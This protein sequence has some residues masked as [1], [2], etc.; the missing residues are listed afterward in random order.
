MEGINKHNEPYYSSAIGTMTIHNENYI[1]FVPHEGV[2]M[3]QLPEMKKEVHFLT[4]HLKGKKLPFISYSQTVQKI[5]NEELNYMK[6]TLPKLI[7]KMAIVVNEGLSK[8]IIHTAIYF[9]RPTFPTKVF[10][11]KNKAMDWLLNDN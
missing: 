2:G 1:S 7:T 8:Y 4:K 9:S 10:T 5:K 3:H 11:N 6:N